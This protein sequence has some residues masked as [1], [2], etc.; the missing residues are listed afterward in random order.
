MFVPCRFEA[1]VMFRG[2]F[3][4]VL[5]LGGYA[6]SAPEPID[7]YCRR[8]EMLRLRHLEVGVRLAD[9]FVAFGAVYLYVRRRASALADQFAGEVEVG[10][11]SPFNAEVFHNILS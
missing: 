11:A 8:I 6:G 5:N 1:V 10:N 9:V 4:G 2:F 3:D 7:H